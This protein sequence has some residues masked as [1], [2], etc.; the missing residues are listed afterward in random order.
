MPVYRPVYFPLLRF[1]LAIVSITL[2]SQ[3]DDVLAGRWI[4]SALVLNSCLQSQ[5][6]LDESKQVLY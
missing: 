1:N 4:K 3:R 2:G 5:C 6:F